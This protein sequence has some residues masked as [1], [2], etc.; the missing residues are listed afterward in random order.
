MP[1]M[2]GV[3]NML[4]LSG[5]ELLYPSLI[6]SQ[7]ARATNRIWRWVVLS[8]LTLLSEKRHPMMSFSHMD[9]A[10]WIVCYHCSS[11]LPLQF[12]SS[13]YM[14]PTGVFPSLNF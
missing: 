8:G 3:W 11:L 7:V 1:S 4:L 14:A 12:V 10:L 13:C 9:V 6:V 5:A 2:N